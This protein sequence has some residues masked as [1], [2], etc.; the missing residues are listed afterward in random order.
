M[1]G[2]PSRGIRWRKSSLSQASDCVE[3]AFVQRDQVLVRNS[4]DR[5]GPLLRFTPAEWKAFVAG[6]RGG[7]FDR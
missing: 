4:K 5:E 3:V 6:V 7:E 2:S 1:A